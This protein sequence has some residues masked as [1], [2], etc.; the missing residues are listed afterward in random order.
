M[1]CRVRGCKYLEWERE[2]KVLLERWERDR[3]ERRKDGREDGRKD[4]RAVRDHVSPRVRKRRDSGGATR[5]PSHRIWLTEIS[6]D[7]T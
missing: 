3:R 6:F 1:V 7:G 2:I 5:T 4:A